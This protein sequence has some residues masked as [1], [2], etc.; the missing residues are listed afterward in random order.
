MFERELEKLKNFQELIRY[1]FKNVDLLA[2]ALTTP[3]FG[4]E[5]NLPDYNILETLGDAV[6]KLIFSV[7]LYKDGINNSEKLTKKKAAVENDETLSKI[8]KDYFNLEKF[9]IKQQKQEIKGTR[10][11]ADVFEAICGAIF[12]DSDNDITLVERKLIDKF[13]RNLDLIIEKSTILNKNRLIEFL[14]KKYR[15]TPSFKIKFR[16]LSS[17]DKPEWIAENPLILDNESQQELV[18]LDKSLKSSKFK[19]KKDAEKDLYIKILDFLE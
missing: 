5:N 16:N 4:R 7:K 17:D 14:Q 11:L 6:L 13:Y 19:S 15:I 3:Q 8:A 2:Q 12:L 18:K 9:I 1:K 10:I